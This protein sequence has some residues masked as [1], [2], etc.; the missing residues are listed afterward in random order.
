MRLITKY[1]FLLF[2]FGLF[3]GMNDS[4]AQC[5]LENDTGAAST[6]PVWTGCSQIT[7]ANDTTFIIVVNPVGSY[8]PWTMNWGDGNISSGPSLAPPNFI[9]HVY[10][11]V[12]N[13]GTVF[14]DTFLTSFIS[15]ACTIPGIVISGYP[16]TA[17][18]EV[19]GGLTQLT[20]APGI[21]TFI[22][23]TNG[24]SGLP[25]MPST[26]FTWD[27]GDGSPPEVFDYTQGG[28]TIMHAY[29]RQTVNCITQVDLTANNVCNLS[30][31]V[32]SQSP[33]LIY[34]LDDAA[35]NAS[36]VLL[37]YPDTVVSFSNGS[38]FNCFAQG[39]TT[40]RY[41]YWNFGDHWGFGHDSIVNWRPSGPPL[42]TPPPS[43]IP[44]AF[45]GVGTYTI[46]MID[47]NLCGQEPASI[48]I[49]IVSPPQAIIASSDDTICAGESIT[50]QNL[51]TGGADEFAWDF[52]DGAGFQTT[53]GGNQNHTYNTA[54]SYTITLAIGI[55]GSTCMDT[56]T[57]DLE[58][59]PSP[60]ALI[61]LDNQMGCDSLL[62]NFSDSSTSLGSLVSW[63]WDFDNGNTSTLQNPGSQFFGFPANFNVS[64]TVT[65]NLNCS[66]SVV[67]VINV[68]QTPIPDF[69]PKNVCAN[70]VAQF[71]DSS[72][73]ATGDPVI[74]WLWDFGDGTPSSTLQNPTHIYTLPGFYTI[75]LAVATANC[76]A[77]DT[78]TVVVE[79]LP[80]ANFT[81]DTTFG[82]SPLAVNFTNTSSVN[83]N[84]FYWE[85]GDGDTSTL[86]DPSHL[87]INNFGVDTSYTISLAAF[88]TF[89]C[90]DTSSQIVDV[91]PNPIAQ[92]SDS[93]QV[94][95]CSPAII[96]FTNQSSNG[97]VTF[98][99]DFDNGSIDQSIHP[100][101]TFIN[102]TN[103]LD[104]FTVVLVAYSLNGCTDTTSK[105][106]I[107]FP[108]PTSLPPILDSGCMPLTTTFP[109]VVGAVNY[110]WTYNF[111]FSNSTAATPSHTYNIPGVDTVSLISSSAAGCKD[112]SEG[113][114]I[115][116]PLPQAQITTLTSIGCSP[117]SVSFTNNSTGATSYYWDFGD[118]TPIDSVNF[119]PTHV[120]N[121]LSDSLATFTVVL[122]AKNNFECFDSDTA[123]ITV[124]PV[125]VAAFSHDTT[126]CSIF[127]VNFTNNS[128]LSATNFSWDFGD[129]GTSN[130]KNPIHPYLNS[131]TTPDTLNVILYAAS[132]T[133]CGD[134]ASSIVVVYPS[135][136]AVFSI[137]PPSKSIT[138]PDTIF[139]IQNLD[140]RWRAKWDFGDGGISND[141]IPG[142]YGYTGW[143]TFTI[144]EIA[145]NEYC[146][147]SA[148]EEVTILP[149][150]PI[151][152]FG[153][154]TEG[155]EDLTVQFINRSLY[156]H[157][158]SWRFIHSTTNATQ[159][160]VDE[161][162]EITFTDPGTYNVSLNVS[163]E[164]G[165][166][167][168][169]KFGFI[170]VYEQPLAEFTF[171]PEE[172]T[173]PN[174]KVVCFNNSRGDNLS[175]DWDFGDGSPHSTVE[176]PEHLYT[177]EGEY[178]ITL[179]SKIISGNITCSD[180]AVSISPV[181]AK[182]S[183]SITTPNAFTP[184][185]NTDPSNSGD[186]GYDYT[187]DGSIGTSNDVFYPVV[188]GAIK[189]Y[190]FMIFNKWGEMLFRTDKRTVGWTGWYRG[191]L[192]QQD[193]YVYKVLAT[194]IDNSEIVLVGDLTLLR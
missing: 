72:Q 123:Y 37:C 62:V 65:N 61:A 71:M 102:T 3:F 104:T 79:Q 5:E 56:T 95:N 117:L 172:V 35:V 70:E 194:R 103:V 15:G 14:A 107:V 55:S 183:G 187:A 69:T 58:V 110:F 28:D 137:N 25:I 101:D 34:D 87:F 176:N 20:C 186:G 122:R 97:A 60:N 49:Q 152:D 149:P 73:S 109:T 155:C 68:Y 82:C 185:T 84:N 18:I 99:W 131:T 78:L 161:N 24:A 80:M 9:T 96:K 124:Y 138:Y 136:T 75:T 90:S 120:F 126:G 114:V 165:G 8:G 106:F 133:A 12:S 88:T 119:S 157:S 134:S 40:Q 22:N 111:G 181:V 173:I 10:T 168:E 193:V 64:L 42:G 23:N 94:I 167:E 145:Y 13:G 162:P 36:A 141:S 29:Q 76:S 17:N 4:K 54:G 132:D 7:S 19:P 179:I 74:S 66:D 32:N 170:T 139:G 128:S 50:F 21:L 144:T 154:P 1:I 178:I 177:A 159:S 30:P 39:N 180:T 153:D 156:A 52:G 166:A 189:K 184:N 160:S 26:I 63:S 129:G 125:I 98:L 127:S 130:D 116:R 135:P 86:S 45:P 190:D 151:A 77:S 171:A 140:L 81:M 143:G 113:L 43:P 150:K 59:L 41:E 146:S 92:F 48:V 16:V 44:I 108:K 89:G 174:Q 192:S 105:D 47:S 51:T 158:Y 147:D 6:N 115:V 91:Y 83:A 169:V 93:A 191:K 100:Q 2:A 175:Y 46:N 57:I 27:W 142:T 67:E 148:Q 31:S 118:G 11:S 121:N 33:V 53:G 112:T 85:F 38:N 182:P 188:T 164:G 163:G